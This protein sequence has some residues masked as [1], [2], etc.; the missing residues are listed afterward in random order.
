MKTKVKTLLACLV[1]LTMACVVSSAQENGSVWSFSGDAEAG[2]IYQ[3][4]FVRI[5][6]GAE[7]DG[8]LYLGF[9]TGIQN[10]GEALDRYDRSWMVPMFL[11]AA[12]SFGHGRVRPYIDLKG[13]LTSNYTNY[14]TGWMLGPSIGIRFKR[15]GVF[16]GYEMMMCNYR[17]PLVE[18]PAGVDI[19]AVY[20]SPLYIVGYSGLSRGVNSLTFGISYRF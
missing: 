6:A 4:G 2:Y 7:L 3:G 19:P 17:A 10:W 1:A 5:S 16:V 8:H 20:G 9:G 14:G 12:Y 11:Q 18:Y 13:G 15:V